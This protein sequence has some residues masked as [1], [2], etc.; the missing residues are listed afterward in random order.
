MSACRS[1]VV[2]VSAPASSCPRRSCSTA[3]RVGTRRRVSAGCA[4]GERV[5][6]TDGARARAAAAWSPRD[7][8]DPSSSTC[9]VVTSSRAPAPRLVVVQALPKGDRGEL[10]VEMMTEVGVDEIVPWAAARCVTR[11]QGTAAKRRWRGGGD[12]REAAKQSRRARFPVVA[13]RAPRPRWRSGSR[14]LRRRVVLHEEADAPLAA[15][16]AGGR[17]DRGGGRPGGRFCAEE[18]AAFPAAGAKPYRLGPR[19]CG[20]RRPAPPRRPS[21][22][23][24]PAAGG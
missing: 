23:R 10:A 18:L 16:A 13:E 2:L 6:L 8:R 9:T 14:R 17:R 19:C 20:P 21:S 24:A 5:V 22:S 11:W 4:V 15:S 7:G 12:G 3:R 1:V